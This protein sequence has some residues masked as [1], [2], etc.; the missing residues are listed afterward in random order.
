MIYFTEK[1]IIRINAKLISQ[2]SPGEMIGI[3]DAAALNMAVNQPKQHVFGREVYPST[4]DKAAILVIN[5]IKRHPFQNAN[6]R[7]ALVAM[8]TF[9]KI[10]GISCQ[11]NRKQAVDFILMITTSDKTFDDLKDETVLVLMQYAHSE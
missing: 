8:M 1:E 3:K 5:L 9:L 4:F 10:N 6:K 11:L 2:L 7:T